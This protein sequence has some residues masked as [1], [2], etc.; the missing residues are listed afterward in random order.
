MC[1][2]TTSFSPTAAARACLL[3][4]IGSTTYCMPRTRANYV[5]HQPCIL[6][7]YTPPSRCVEC[8]QCVSI[9]YVMYRSTQSRAAVVPHSLAVRWEAGVVATHPRE[10][11]TGNHS[12]SDS[13]DTSETNPGSVR[14]IALCTPPVISALI[15]PRHRRTKSPTMAGRS[16]CAG[17]PDPQ[18]QQ[19]GHH[20]GP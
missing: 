14:S 4:Q 20:R 9:F 8:E 3:A 12:P 17:R 6:S 15:S 5:T 1:V 16:I 7:K 10:S 11:E 18:H 13:A 19:V 2:C